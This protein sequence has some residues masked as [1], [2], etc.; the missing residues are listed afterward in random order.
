MTAVD[1]ASFVETLATHSGDAILP[2]FRT[3][4]A[5]LDKSTDGAF[6]PVTEA[7]RA[8]EVAM[9]RLINANF[10]SHGIIGEEFGAE[11]REAE[12]VWVLDPIDGT[13][14][15]LCGLPIWGTLIG[16]THRGRPVY[17]MIN[18]PF[19]RERFSGDGKAARYEG[20]AGRRTLRVRA[21]PSVSEAVISTTHP[22]MMAPPERQRYDRLETRAKLSRYGGDC[23]AYAMLAAGHIDLVV[24]SGLNPYDIVAI[25]PIVEGAGGVITSWSG[26]DASR[27]GTIIAAGDKR[28][29][30]EALAILN[31]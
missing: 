6:D 13:K 12:Y 8:G 30:E 15:F 31:S 28:V 18:Q 22:G 14:A 20:P 3:S 2:F 26:E 25:I 19:S 21:C 16:L 11:R 9:R 24:E 23:Y 1:F 17:G 5:A 27:G 10:P 7:D 4:L 29:H